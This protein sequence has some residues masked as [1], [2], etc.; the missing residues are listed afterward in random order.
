MR[1]ILFEVKPGEFGQFGL[2][3]LNRTKALN[4]LTFEMI[5]AMSEKLIE[6]ADDDRIQAVIVRSNSEKAFCA[7]GDVVSLYQNGREHKE[8]AM[9]FFW[10]EYRLNHLIHHYPK[11]Y[12]PILDGITM[13]GG[14]GISLHGNCPIATERFSFAM[15]ETGIGFFPDVGGSYLLANS[16]GATGYYLGLTGARVS[17]WDT[18]FCGLTPQVIQSD[19]IES[20][21]DAIFNTDLSLD[22]VNKVHDLFNEFALADD[23]SQMASDRDAIEQAFGHDDVLAIMNDLENQN[24][25]WS[26]KTLK[27]LNHKAPLSLCVTL[28][29]LKRAHGL[30]MGECMQMEYRMVSRF[31]DGNDF[32]EGV[33]ALLIDKDKSP[34]WSH[35]SISDV[36]KSEV[37]AYF[38]PLEQEL[39][40]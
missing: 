3:T 18:K 12:I 35:Q 24:S 19:A 2:V 26:H 16:K 23:E 1:D 27:T 22:G 14:V 32:Y 25:E 5:T 13:G 9:A 30:S 11:P 17:V 33:R 7:G 36:T 21:V 38:S 39:E 6:W 31:M 10:H 40:L 20:L 8:K 28:E 37:E 34:K 29:Q 4:A 15:P